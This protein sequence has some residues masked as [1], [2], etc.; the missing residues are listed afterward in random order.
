MKRYRI[1]PTLL[2][3]DE[4][5][6][7]GKKFANHRYIGD[8]INAVKIFNEKE[9][10]ELCLLD[11]GATRNGAQP[12]LQLISEIASE[13]FMPVSYGGGLKDIGTVSQILKSGIEKVIFNNAALQNPQLISE[14]AAKFGSSS[15]VVSIDAKKVG[16]DY[17][18]FARNGQN[19]TGKAATQFAQEMEKA[20][21][22]EIILTAIDKEG[23]YSG[24]D[25]DL[26]KA[27]C[28]NLEIP[29]IANGGAG[30]VEH[31]KAAINA[32]ASA[33]TAGSMFVF[34]GKLEGVLITYP[35]SPNLFN[36]ADL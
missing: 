33:V 30:L 17:H 7:K 27:V 14:T 19:D 8:P 26:I 34:Y 31:F 4:G 5:L 9:V 15:T 1:I 25:L 35:V 21:A 10:D 13:A 16:T 28:S 20:G 24:Y 29:V 6:V 2:I 36:K 22:G 18:V 12:N 23:S 3:D 11:I 32:G